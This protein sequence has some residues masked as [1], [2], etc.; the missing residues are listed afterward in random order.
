MTEVD[1]RI[2]GL[3]SAHGSELV[4]YSAMC[5]AI[6]E[7]HKV[8]E[9][10]EI[11]DRAHAL[12]VYAA[13][14]LN[15][16]AER[17]A[18]EIRL[19]AERRWGELYKASDKNKGTRLIGGRMTRPPGEEPT[20]DEMGV[21]KDQASKWQALA[22]VPNDEFESA[23]LDPEVKP[24]TEGILSRRNE[25][26]PRMDPKALWLWGRLRDFERDR[27]SER[28]PRELLSAMTDT[29]QADVVRIAPTVVAF[30]KEM[31]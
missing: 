23:L 8:D 5:T 13:Q 9:V 21:S 14:A 15:M 22:S 16:D 19:R 11:R 6:L 17:K 7:C 31:E 2:T 12:E 26:T 28:D 4:R 29:M 30:L 1:P 27:I 18:C 20:L 10:K 25:D 3:M 24:S